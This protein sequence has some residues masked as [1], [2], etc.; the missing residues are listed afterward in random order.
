MRNPIDR[1][2]SQA[3][4]N[5]RKGQQPFDAVTTKRFSIISGRRSIIRGDYKRILE[6]GSRCFRKNKCWSG[7]SKLTSGR[8]NS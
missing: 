5:C 6:H 8:R 7:S 4:M 1:A 3:L 2:W